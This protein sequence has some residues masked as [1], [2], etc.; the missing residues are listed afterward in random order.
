MLRIKNLRYGKDEYFLINDLGP[1]MIMHPFKPELVYCLINNL[2]M[3]FYS[4]IMDIITLK[5]G[6]HENGT[7]ENTY[8][9]EFRGASPVEFHS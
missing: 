3:Y 2:N 5:E 6:I 9:F 8:S 1:K 7:T 4:C